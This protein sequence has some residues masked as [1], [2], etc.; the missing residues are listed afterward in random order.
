[1]TA[2]TAAGSEIPRQRAD[3]KTR[4]HPLVNGAGQPVPLVKTAI[5]RGWTNAGLHSSLSTPG[6]LRSDQHLLGC[7]ADPIGLRS[8]P[9]TRHSASGVQSERRFRT[10]YAP[11][12]AGLQMPRPT[13]PPGSHRRRPAPGQTK[14]VPRDS[15][16]STC[17][18]AIRLFQSMLPISPRKAPVRRSVPPWDLWGATRAGRVRQYPVALTARVYALRWNQTALRKKRSFN[19]LV[20]R[21]R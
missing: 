3:S 20:E 7:A 1:L 10:D 21:P 18:R 13:V 16:L 2:L 12:P 19:T 11:W 17:S 5:H 6:G 4:R 9:T 14:H 15:W 8:R